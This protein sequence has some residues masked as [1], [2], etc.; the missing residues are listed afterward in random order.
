MTT[1]LLLK[2]ANL[3]PLGDIPPGAD[4]LLIRDG[5]IASLG[6]GRD[7]IK[8][9]DPSVQVIDLKGRTVLPGFID[10]H[11]HLAETGL[12]RQG[13]DLG[14]AGDITEALQML[15]DAF[16]GRD[17]PGFFRAHSLDPSLMTGGRYFTREELDAI[18]SR[19]PIFILRRD[20][21]SCVVNTSFL[22]HCGL[23][24][25]IS[26]VETDAHTG[27][28]TG[29]LRAEALERAQAC[30]SRLLGKEDREV[31]MRQACQQA[32]RR[33]VTTLHA[34]CGRMEDIDLLDR[35]VGKLPIEVVPYPNTTDVD[36]VIARGWPR[37]GGDI[38]VDGSLGSH[39][40]A[41]MNPYADRPGERGRLYYA[42]K[43]LVD[44]LGPAH[45][46]GLQIS[47][48]AIGD[49]AVEELL[50]AYEELLENR[51]R[52]DH[53]YRIE[54]AELLHA[55]Q[56]RRISQRGIVLSVQPAFESFWGGD[57]GMY[58]SRLGAER[59]MRTNP[60]R[61]L[62]DVGITL[63]GGSDSPITP[64]DPLAGIAAAVGHPHAQHRLSVVEAVR[65][66]T[67]GGAWAAF[68][69]DR[70]GLLREG[71]QADLVVLA[72]DPQRVPPGQIIGIEIAMVICA[73]RIVYKR[74]AEEQPSASGDEKI[75]AS[76]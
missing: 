73:G 76:P 63:A 53:R 51:A 71:W 2:K 64:I 45:V 25:E 1:Q 3:F 7:L 31:A 30:R 57:A 20:G 74:G 15:T 40:A 35:L 65:M 68:Q 48:H 72:K 5:R 26:G 54:H 43:Q 49:R 32:I 60:L 61:Q 4:A 62:L 52:E 47:L 14:P 69:E 17:D 23:T 27:Q 13:V 28:P 22:R 10:A 42:R 75:I 50:S 11:V 21:H 36:T 18:S 46:A 44:L 67:F 38:L 12:L 37:I 24:S 55:H 34:V 33:G 41:L 8:G 6:R 16:P 9:L 66:F 56:I 39:T 58:A 19:V 29:T 70:K 59:V